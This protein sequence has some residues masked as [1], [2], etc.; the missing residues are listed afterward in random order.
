MKLSL[1]LNGFFTQKDV[2][3][4]WNDVWQ[5]L[6]LL[7]WRLNS[8]QFPLFGKDYWNLGAPEGS[9]SSK[10]FFRIVGTQ[11]CWCLGAYPCV[12]SDFPSLWNFYHIL[13]DR[14]WMAS[15]PHGHEDGQRISWWSWSPS[16]MGLHYCPCTGIP[17]ASA[18]YTYAWVNSSQC[19]VHNFHCVLIS[20]LYNQAAGH[21]TRNLK[22]WPQFGFW[23]H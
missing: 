11:L 12:S 2:L 7:S 5:Y 13:P 18:E 20:L 10:I 1:L 23:G 3:I 22:R 14:I 19:T 6:L 8:V 4:C 16:C 15:P 17:R 21:Q 9:T